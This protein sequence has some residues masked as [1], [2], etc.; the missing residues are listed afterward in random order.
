MI[1]IRYNIIYYFIM[2]ALRGVSLCRVR[3][4]ARCPVT[5][6]AHGEYNNITV[7]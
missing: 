3:M 5:C 6:S 1:D 7:F 2:K 4:V